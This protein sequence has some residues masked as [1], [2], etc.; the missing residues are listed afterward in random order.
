MEPKKRLNVEFIFLCVSALIFSFVPFLS[1]PLSWVT[2]LFHEVSHGIAVLV[3]GGE[4]DAIY[5]H[6][7]GSGLC[8][9]TGGVVFIVALSG[10]L[11]SV[12]FGLGMYKIAQISR[13]RSIKILAASMML[14]IIAVGILYGRSLSTWVVLLVL[15]GLFLAIYQ[16]RNDYLVKMALKFIAIYVVFDGTL[17]PLGLIDGRHYGDGARLAEIT[18]LPEF[19]W[20]VVWVSCGLLGV[21]R[22]WK[23]NSKIR[24]SI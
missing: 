20:V 5:L 21:F 9:F 1:A 15:F 23:I 22:L 10:Y 12:L 11:G 6:L 3:T 24:L 8:R 18:F 16:F 4:V 17:A 2:V 13:Q 7:R 19:F 14:L